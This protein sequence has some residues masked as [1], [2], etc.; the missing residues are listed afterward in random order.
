MTAS[1]PSPLILP[2]PERSDEWGMLNAGLDVLWNG[3]GISDQLGLLYFVSLVL[4][5]SSYV[6]TSL[7]KLEES[8]DC[9]QEG[10]LT[11]CLAHSL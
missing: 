1:R 11:C 9:F 3:M 6:Y 8:K 10:V 2:M 5:F 7:N 4:F